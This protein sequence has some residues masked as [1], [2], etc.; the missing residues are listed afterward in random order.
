MVERARVLLLVKSIVADA[1]RVTSSAAAPRPAGGVQVSWIAVPLLVAL[2]FRRVDLCPQTDQ[3]LEFVSVLPPAGTSLAVAEAPRSHRTASTSYFPRRMRR[4]GPRCTSEPKVRW[5]YV[6]CQVPRWDVTILGARQR[7]IG[8]LS[9]AASRRSPSRAGRRRHWPQRR[10]HAA[11]PGVETASSSSCRSQTILPNRYPTPVARSGLLQS[12]SR[13][14]SAASILRSCPRPPLSVPV[15]RPQ[16]A[17]RQG[18]PH[19]IA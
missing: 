2:P 6:R 8:V 11:A 17:Q 3:P 4:A 13:S 15:D 16:Q 7:A 19:C 14:T 1:P 12:L 10:T 9:R 18:H 5:P